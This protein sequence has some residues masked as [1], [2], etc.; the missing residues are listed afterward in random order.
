MQT[1]PPGPVKSYMRLILVRHGQ[2]PCNVADIWHGWDPCQ[3]TDVGLAQARAVGARLATEPI[4]AI[5][6][7]DLHRAM[8]TAEAIAAPHGL[9]PIPET[10]LRERDAGAFQ[11]LVSDQVISRNPD[12]WEER[13]RDKWG[14]RPPEGETLHEVLARA[15]GVVDRLRGQYP[16]GTVVAVTHMAT[17][18]ALISSLADISIERT[19]EMEFPSTG[20]SI[21]RFDGDGIPE[22]EMLNDGAHMP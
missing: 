16:D 5:H 20:V 14:W 10:G 2:T 9:T 7:S 1:A 13:A 4:V 15:M 11:G 17:K 18:R 3:L 8:Q 19:F 22:V 6:S 12:V 21:F